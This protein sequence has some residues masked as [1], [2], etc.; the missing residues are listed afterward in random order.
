MIRWFSGVAIS[1]GDVERGTT[2]RG[3]CGHSAPS[4]FFPPTELKAKPASRLT[5]PIGKDLP[6]LVED[7]CQPLDL[8]SNIDLIG[9]DS[10]AAT[11]AER[12]AEMIWL[13]A[14]SSWIA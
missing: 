12:L 2:G 8:S 1:G 11:S 14:G 9:P 6:A 5:R 7:G 3:P 13:L 4:A 10:R